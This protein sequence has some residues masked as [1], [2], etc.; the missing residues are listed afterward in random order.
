MPQIKKRIYASAF[1]LAATLLFNVFAYFNIA[2]STKQ[3]SR[4][5]DALLLISKV[6]GQTQ[7]VTQNILVVT[8]HQ[9]FSE[10]IYLRHKDELALAIKDYTANYSALSQIIGGQFLTNN[11]TKE[12]KDRFAAMSNN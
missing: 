3:S 10:E 8:I 11:N 9:S 7:E 4:L 5:E 1:I 12:L 2:N 6:Q